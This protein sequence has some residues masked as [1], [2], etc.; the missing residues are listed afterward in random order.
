VELTELV[1]QRCGVYVL[2]R[3][4]ELLYVGA[5]LNVLSRIGDHVRK[6]DRGYGIGFDRVLVRFC[7]DPKRVE[8]RLIAELSPPFNIEHNG[9]VLGKVL[10]PF[11]VGIRRR[12]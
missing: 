3:G 11:P 5:S 12:V 10:P 7:E 8:A 2:L 9:R 6:R 4:E 1:E